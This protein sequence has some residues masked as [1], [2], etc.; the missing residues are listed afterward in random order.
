MNLDQDPLLIVD[1]FLA[2]WPEVSKECLMSLQERIEEEIIGLAQD[3]HHLFSSTRSRLQYLLAKGRID[4]ELYKQLNR[5]QSLFEKEQDAEP[6]LLK[7]GVGIW[8]RCIQLRQPCTFSERWRAYL[9]ASENPQESKS[10]HLLEEPSIRMSFLAFTEDEKDLKFILQADSDEIHTVSLENL[11]FKNDHLLRQCIR[12]LHFPVD[13][14][15]WN[16]RKMENQWHADFLILMP[17]YLVDV[18]TV[19][20]CYHD[21]GA[22]P[23]KFLLHQFVYRPTG[24]AALTGNAVN[25][26]LDELIIN[27]NAQLPAV[28]RNLFYQNPLTFCL[29]DNAQIRQFADQIKLHYQH[30]HR[31]VKS[32]FLET[33]DQLDQC[34]LEPSFYS[35]HYGIQGRLDIFSKSS[36]KTTII[37]LKSGKPYQPNQHGVNSEHYAQTLLYYLLVQS[38]YGHLQNTDAYVLY[39]SQSEHPLRKAPPDPHKIRHLVEVRNTL[40]IMQLHLAFH[41]IDQDYIFDRLQV[42]HFQKTESFTKR[43]GMLLVQLYQSLQSF[44]KDYFKAFA[45]FIAREQILSKTGRFQAQYS[46]GMASLWLLSEEEKRKQY[47]LIS[48]LEIRKVISDPNDFPLL[49]LHENGQGSQLANFRTGDTLVLYPKPSALQ[50]QIFKGTLIDQKDGQYRIRLR[51]RQFPEKLLDKRL[52]WNIE[53]D[54]LDRSF[55]YQFQS[56]TEWAGSNDNKRKLLLGVVPPGI[57]D[58]EPIKLHSDTPKGLLPL[59]H[60]IL[61]S[62]DYFLVWGPPGSG[63]TSMV[64]RYLTEA[65]VLRKKE[66]VL[67]LAYTNRAVDE[68]CEV[69]DWLKASTGQNYLRIG[70]RYGVQEK[71]RSQLLDDQARKTKDRMDMKALI[72]QTSIFTGTIAS[73]LGKKELF[74]LKLFDTLIVDEA[75]QILEP[76]LLGLLTRFKRFIL[77]GDHMQLPAVTAQ[78]ASESSILSDQLKSIGFESLSTSLFERLMKQCQRNGWNHSYE[79]LQYQGRMHYEIM[80]YPSEAFYG[81]RLS[82]LPSEDTNRQMAPLTSRYERSPGPLLE[83]LAQARTLFVP[84]SKASIHIGLKTN[85]EEARMVERIAEQLCQL[86][87]INQLHW[88]ELTLGIICPFRAQIALIRQCFNNHGKLKHLPI[89]VDTAERYQGGARDII[90]LC[91]VVNEIGQLP[92]ICSLNETGADRKLN[93]AITRAKEQI[94]VLGNPEVLIASKHYAVLMQRYRTLNLEATQPN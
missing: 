47:G 80:Q 62:D 24:L 35:V 1:R 65:L 42:N 67:L 90:I 46:E 87:E 66:K 31:L 33:V 63:K 52:Q 25:Y 89:T 40:I 91:T 68:M 9:D 15:A 71:F 21:L 57:L 7:V 60:K 10:T 54:F 81:G 43:D 22:H 78:S 39:S 36:G 3:D 12:Y 14:I 72:D 85:P 64:I 27:Q 37:E 38:V 75:S 34:L 84:L 88:D 92:Q 61:Q 4:Q 50:E 56:L 77:V 6:L 8:L 29:L 86:Y 19:A 45:S 28:L 51:T 30:L 73:I 55:S 16:L 74:E 44:E 41:P 17:D 83:T 93:V 26:L 13:A 59:L 58:A 53:H 23:L 70:S 69:L 20:S 79:M 82:I 32:R 76:Q 18:T 11:G 48:Q 5:F 49:E 2:A 94:I